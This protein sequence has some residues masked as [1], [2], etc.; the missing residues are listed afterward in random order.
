MPLSWSVEKVADHEEVTAEG[1]PW[2]ITELLIFTTMG[3]GIGQ[4]TDANAEEFWTRMQVWA[5]AC[6]HEP[7]EITLDDIK[8]RVG[9]RTNASLKSK[10]AFSGQ[11]NRQLRDR[12]A[13]LKRHQQS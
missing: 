2:E 3:V 11:V 12:A 7:L 6:G 5:M 4:I 8:R 13:T 1:R 9:L 10:A